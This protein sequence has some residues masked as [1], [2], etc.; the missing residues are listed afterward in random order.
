MKKKHIICIPVEITNREFNYKLLLSLRFAELGYS[1]LFGTKPQINKYIF[2][3][4]HLYNFIYFDKGL[5][6]ERNDYYKLLTKYNNIMVNLDDEQVNTSEDFFE[7]K[8]NNKFPISSLRY[9]DK[10]FIS[11]KLVINYFKKNELYKE[12]NHKFVLSGHPKFDIYD[13]KISKLLI[14]K[15]YNKKNILVCLSFVFYNGLLDLKS[16]IKLYKRHFK[17][18]NAENIYKETYNYQKILFYNFIELIKKL[19]VNFNEYQIIVRPHPSEKKDKYTQNFK[20]IKN[21]KIDNNI[22]VEEQLIQSNFLIHH[23][24]SVSIDY[25]LMGKQPISFLP[26]GENKLLQTKT[27]RI[28]KIFNKVEEIILNIRNNTKEKVVI[29]KYDIFTNNNSYTAYKKILLE[30]QNYDNLKVNKISR[31]KSIIYY[32]NY[33][34][35]FS[36]IKNYIYSITDITLLIKKQ[37][38][39]NKNQFT[40]FD[41][42]FNKFKENNIFRVVIKREKIN[43]FLYLISR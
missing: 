28:S 10:C 9:A 4:S 11:S 17:G 31:L 37:K 23:D 35:L 32:V 2:S 13:K 7:L 6:E 33:I 15:S 39:I 5:T 40:N 42:I 26:L 43:N 36:N 29:D 38:K 21:I 3:K 8:F 22:P 20:H 12:Y 18:S 1:V 27:L 30:I 41:K 25:Y 19:A 34:F 24:S 14:N 16:G